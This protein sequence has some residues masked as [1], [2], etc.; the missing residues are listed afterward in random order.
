MY[1]IYEQFGSARKYVSPVTTRVFLPT[2][3]TGYRKK[4]AKFKFQTKN[5]SSTGLYRL[6]ARFGQQTALV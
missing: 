4:P 1:S 3:L 5:D 6:A 2:G